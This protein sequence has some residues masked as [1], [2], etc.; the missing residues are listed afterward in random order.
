MSTIKKGYKQ[1]EVGVIPE[2][3]I[4]ERLGPH[5]EIKSGESPSL[6]RFDNDGTPYFKVEQLN[7]NDKYLSDTPY[8]ISRPLKKLSARHLM[9]T[10]V[11]FEGARSGGGRGAWAQAASRF[12]SLARL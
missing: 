7:N 1:T 4:A 12:G 3:W 10:G 11:C 9:L 5:V 6:F 2:D 8:F